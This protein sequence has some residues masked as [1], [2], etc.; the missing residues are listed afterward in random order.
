[1]SGLSVPI[2]DEFKKPQG[3]SE[4]NKW[5]LLLEEAIRKK[6]VNLKQLITRC[7][8]GLKT[9]PQEVLDKL[10]CVED[11][12]D[13]VSGYITAEELRLHIELWVFNDK[14]YYS[15]KGTL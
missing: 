6:T 12:Q 15:G 8:Y 13:I 14:P 9:D 10:L 4:M 7:C 11:E 2:M 5:D 1:M 3:I